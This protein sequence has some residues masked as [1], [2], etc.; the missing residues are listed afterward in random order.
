MAQRK[1]Y[2][3]L[4]PQTPVTLSNGSRINFDSIDG[5]MTGFYSTEDDYLQAELRGHMEGQRFGITEITG[6]EYEDQYRLK[7]NSGEIL[8]QDLRREEFGAHLPPTSPLRAFHPDVVA[9]AVGV[10]TSDV[11]M[12]T[13]TP[14]YAQAVKPPDQL[15]EKQKPNVGRR[16]KASEKSDK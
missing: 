4:V 7:K 8:R 3:K 11:R 14:P 1:F 13:T 12:E 9:A 15:D 5:G 2:R 10:N 16:P 6:Q